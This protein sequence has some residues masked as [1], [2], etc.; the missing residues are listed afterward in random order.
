LSALITGLPGHAGPDSVLSYI[1]LVPIVA[2]IAYMAFL[3]WR[4]NR[5]PQDDDEEQST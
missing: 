3:V 2:G 1:W 4:E 5:T